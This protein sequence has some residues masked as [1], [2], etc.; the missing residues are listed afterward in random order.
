[1]HGDPSYTFYLWIHFS[2]CSFSKT[3]VNA[4]IYIFAWIPY[5]PPCWR[6]VQH[7]SSK[8][9]YILK[10]IGNKWWTFNYLIIVNDKDHL[11]CGAIFMFIWRMSTY[12]TT[13]CLP[14]LYV[15]RQ[16]K[17]YVNSLMNFKLRLPSKCVYFAHS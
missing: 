12:L 16:R 17:Y 10:R 5:R 13:M 3:I 2:L 8:T 1:M 4:V 9:S 6:R 7:T 15:Y 11:M 14:M